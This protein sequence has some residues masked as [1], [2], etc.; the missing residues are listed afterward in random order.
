VIVA[1]VA[2]RVVQVAL[3]QV[4]DVVAVRHRLVA[5]PWPMLV[6]GV[7]PLAAVAGR[8]AVGIGGGNL[9]H[10]LVDMVAV[11]MMQVAVMQVVDM[12]AMADGGMPAAGTVNVGVVAVDGVV[13]ICHGWLRQLR[14]SFP[15]VNWI[16]WHDISNLP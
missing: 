15:Q 4:V 16:C 7:V 3:H 1:V 10:V 5:A 2:V 9:D 14:G 12:I 13:G 8:A 11:R 6:V